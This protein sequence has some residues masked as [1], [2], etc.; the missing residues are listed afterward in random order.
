MIKSLLL[1]SAIIFSFKVY[2]EKTLNVLTYNV[3]MVDVPFKM[4]SQDI[5]ARAAAIPAEVAKT[6]ADIIALQEVWPD[7]F[8]IQL[9][10]DFKKLGYKYSYFEDLPYSLLLRG[11]IGN[12]LLIVSKYPIETPAEQAQRVL[13]FT[14]FT[15]PDEYFARKGALHVKALIPDWGAVNLYDTHY[16]AVSFDADE[17][18]FDMS[19]E[20]S[21]QKQAHELIDF[22]KKTSGDA[23]VLLMGDFNSYSKKFFKDKF[24]DELVPDYSEMTCASKNQ[25]CLGLCDSFHDSHPLEAM[26]PTVDPDHNPYVGT[27][28]LYKARSAPRMIDYIFVSKSPKIAVAA[29]SVVLANPLTIKGRNGSLPLSDHYGI[30]TSLSLQ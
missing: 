26:V 27:A 10:D 25:K 2:A 6:G 14:D 30:M 28:A 1:I 20:T 3:W 4:A 18:Q 7:K 8:K 15:R 13:G 11:I 24:T 12:G 17:L 23:P 9:A 22:I 5:E 29:S 21:R 19:H 16:G